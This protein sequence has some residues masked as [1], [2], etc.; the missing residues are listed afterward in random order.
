MSFL[1]LSNYV[2]SALRP[3]TIEPK[4]QGEA[5]YKPSGAMGPLAL[6]AL[7]L[8]LVATVPI[9]AAYAVFAVSNPLVY[10]TVVGTAFLGVATGW[11][12][13]HAAKL[14]K[15]RNRIFVLGA[16]LLAALV[17]DYANWVT[18]I[19]VWAGEEQWIVL[20]P[21]EILQIVNLV[22][23]DSSMTING[24]PIKGVVLQLFW[25]TELVIIAYAAVNTALL[26]HG[27][28]AFCEKSGTWATVKEEFGPFVGVLDPAKLREQA[29]RGDFSTCAAWPSPTGSVAR[30]SY[31]AAGRTRTS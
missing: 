11:L 22:A 19:F 21:I 16:A 13:Y 23:R 28:L 26:K 27:R 17:A 6:P 7:A 14:A 18:A 8:A 10:F 15:V 29:G 1:S 12:V 9:A 2:W 31:T 3:T 25:A 20:N 5:F 4:Y 24:I 30:P